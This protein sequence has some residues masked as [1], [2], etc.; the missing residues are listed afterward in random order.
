[1]IASNRQRVLV[2]DIG[3]TNARFAIAER[4][5]SGATIRDLMIVRTKDYPTFS[6]AWRAFA[7]GRDLGGLGALGVSFAGPVGAAPVRLT[8]GA[9]S[10][11]PE[12]LAVSL[13]LQTVTVVNDLAA[14]ARAVPVLP[15][16]SFKRLCG[17][18]SGRPLGPV[19]SVVGLGTGLGLALLVDGDGEPNV[20]ACEGGHIGYAPQSDTDFRILKQLQE[21][22]GRVSVE[23]I[24]SGNALRDLIEARGGQ[25]DPCDSDVD[26]WA[27]AIADCNQ[28]ANQALEVMLANL[29]SVAGDFV[30]AHGSQS[31][32]L[33]GGLMGRLQ[34]RLEDSEFADRFYA[35]GRLSNHLANIP[36]FCLDD[37]IA[38]LVG[39]ALSLPPSIGLQF[40]GP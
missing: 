35:K 9:W 8:N 24:V 29:G 32:V 39:A 6:N 28:V 25:I 3:G 36:V 16:G 33:A 23:R 1:M 21:R 22:Y 2:A 13:G 7:A 14:I 18:V 38:G 40:D 27:A 4:N 26:L 15:D 20:I 17:P 11:D 10:L 12:E 31:L 19:T 37:D 34:A 5:G 30:L